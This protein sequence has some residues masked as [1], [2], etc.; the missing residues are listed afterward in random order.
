MPKVTYTANATIAFLAIWGI[1]G[2]IS[3]PIGCRVERI[4]PKSGINHC[5]NS[6][7]LFNPLLKYPLIDQI[8]WMQALT[9]IDI[10]TEC[11]TVLI[12]LLG[13]YRN[14]MHVEDKAIV[15]VAFF[16]RIP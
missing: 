8:P 10:I 6:V 11:F 9:I 4:L 14:K 13:L 5:V 16:T 7:S 12:P 2:V 3:V 1:A 15:M